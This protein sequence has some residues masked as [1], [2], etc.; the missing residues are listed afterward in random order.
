MAETAKEHSA[1]GIIFEDGRVLAIKMRNLKGEEVWTFPK[2]HLDP[3]ETAEQAAL[4]E[5]L[6]E[7]GWDC[8]ILSDLYTARYSFVRGSTEVDKDV[9][10]FLV[11]RAGGDGIPT[12]PDEVLEARWMTLEEAE[13]EMAYVS[14][15]ELLDLLKKM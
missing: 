11:K 13:R 5:V 6:E 2:G 15:L 14:D 7:T 1:G 3:G 12:T 9:R 4:R 10:W 8:E